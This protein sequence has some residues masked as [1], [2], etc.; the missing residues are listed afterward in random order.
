MK[1]SLSWLQQY[2]PMKLAPAELAEALT[3]VGLAVD[4]VVD[5][6]AWLDTVLIARVLAVDSHPAADQIKICRVD[7]GRDTVSI[8]CGAANVTAGMLAPLALPGTVLPNGA[9]IEASTIRGQRS[10]GM[11][12]SEAELALGTD[13][14]GIMV[15]DS[16]HRVG[17]A[18]NMA[19]SLSDPVL[20]IDLTPNRADCLSMI[21]VAREVAAIQGTHLSYP[22]L[23]LTDLDDRITRLTAVTIEAPDHCS[24]YAARVLEDVVVKPSPSWLQDRLVSIGLRPINNIVDVTNFVMMEYGQPLH[25]FDLDRLAGNCIVVRTATPGE[26]FFTLDQK[27]RLL[28]AEML[29]I[30][31]GEKSVAVAGV[32]GGLNSEIQAASTRGLVESACLVPRS[33]AA[34]RAGSG[35]G[36]NCSRR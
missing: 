27:E 22:K 4:A 20:E 21:G 10:E 23:D 33:V 3:L 7:T 25:A 29:M 9:V 14:D 2:T 12:C 8:V 15:L 17:T 28:D 36:R 24:R 32:M 5:R 19:L 31:D 13:A 6:F 18:L 34:L 16:G 35:P 1:V 26:V 11:L 30:R